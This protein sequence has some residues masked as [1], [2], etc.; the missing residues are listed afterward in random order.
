[1][2]KDYEVIVAFNEQF[3][4]TD[5]LWH[6]DQNIVLMV[7]KTEKMAWLKLEEYAD[8]ERSVRPATANVIDSNITGGCP[9]SRCFLDL[10]GKLLQ[11]DVTEEKIGQR[12]V[13]T[14]NGINI[15]KPMFK[16]T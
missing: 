5:I 10:D 8:N 9:F 15:Y 11:A 12:I 7:T 14:L 13:S 16:Y 4:F 1:M 3:R 2:H 6:Y